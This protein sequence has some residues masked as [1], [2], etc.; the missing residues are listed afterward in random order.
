MSR[1]KK[2]PK[3]RRN[4]LRPFIILL[5]LGF[6]AIAAFSPFGD[7][8]DAGKSVIQNHAADAGQQVQPA[9]SD[10]SQQS[11][12]IVETPAASAMPVAAS[13]TLPNGSAVSGNARRVD[14]SGLTSADV[15]TAAGILASLPDV[16]VIDVGTCTLSGSELAYLQAVAPNARFSGTFRINGQDV[17]TR[18]SSIDLKG[19]TSDAVADTAA[20]LS[21]LRH[22]EYIDL[23]DDSSGLSWSDVGTIEAACPDAVTD[24]RF[25]FMDEQYTTAD[26][27][28]N[29][30]YKTMNDGGAAVRAI[31]PYMNSCLY[32][33]MD[34]CGVSDTDMDAIRQDFPDMKV[35]WRINFGSEHVYSVRTDVIKILASK[36]SVGGLLSTED[37]Q[38]LKYCT[39]LM[40]LDLGH[41]DDI[42]DIS[43]IANFPRLEVCIIAMDFF[44][45]LSPIA[46]CTNLEY[47]EIQ[48]TLV[49]DL[50]PLANLKNLKH[51][52]ICKLCE[53]SGTVIDLSPLMG[54]DQ[55][56]R[57]WIGCVTKYPDGQLEE[58]QAALP[59][60]LIDTEA[61]DP[62]DHQ[63][64]QI[65]WDIENT[66]VIVYH[67]RYIRLRD[68]FG[69]TYLAYSFNYLDPYYKEV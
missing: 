26:K 36:P 10:L 32:L 3:P 19:L 24:Y 66:G 44:E 64:R 11:A 57:L 65:S 33:D 18:A 30:R 69:Y 12:A 56:E 68:Q 14:L 48:T 38:C 16:A 67:P 61:V 41:N 60:T 43:F 17:S 45:D 4:H 55:L 29:L 39:D 51:L 9:E 54:L 25:S 37:V 34:S 53:D 47:L 63:W 7:F 21:C 27:L 20:A 49:H 35:V 58:L 22:V 2:N 28:F 40:Y 52:N 6:F 59:N 62:H 1:K 31:L 15:Q 23:G 42:D 8:A 5:F 46:A 13:A 50:T